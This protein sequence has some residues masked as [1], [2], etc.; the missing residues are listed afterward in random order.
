MKGMCAYLVLYLLLG[1]HGSAGGQE[2][3]GQ[4]GETR[5]PV[6]PVKAKLKGAGLAWERLNSQLI[7]LT[8]SGDYDRALDVGKQAL[9]MA[10]QSA[11]KDHPDVA[12]ALNN[13]ARV[14]SK[15]EQY[16]EALPL[17]QRALAVY[18]AHGKDHPNVAG[19]L[20]NLAVVY[21]RLDKA[22]MALPLYKRALSLY[23]KELGENHPH[24]ASLL[25]NLA[26]IHEG[27]GDFAQAEPLYL[28][29]LK[30][31]E[32]SLGKNHPG[33][34]STMNNLAAL[35]EQTDRKDKALEM[36]VRALQIEKGSQ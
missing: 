12:V 5:R 17:Y 28:R 6:P 30:I 2:N 14:H 3:S 4:A 36:Q 24:V 8:K 22:Q 32:S 33:L 11:G 27:E 35:Y 10:R 13:L 34:V 21:S 31:K 26:V 7:S 20:N 1:C 19:S 29:A 23:E 25:N 16:E 9:E 18:E 15:K